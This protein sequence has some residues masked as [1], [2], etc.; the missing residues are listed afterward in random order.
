MKK[1]VSV[2]LTNQEL[3]RYK[4]INSIFYFN[5]SLIH[6][7]KISKLKNLIRVKTNKI[8]ILGKEK[9]KLGSIKVNIKYS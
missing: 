5:Y 4:T 7:L 8:L 2:K 3:M 1:M 6:G 9:L